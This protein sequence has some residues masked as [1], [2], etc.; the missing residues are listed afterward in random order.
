LTIAC[1]FSYIQNRQQVAAYN[2]VI[3][4]LNGIENS[5]PDDNEQKEDERFKFFIRCTLL[6]FVANFKY[7][8]PRILPHDMS[9]RTY[10]VE[11]LSPIFRAFRNA[12]P[13][14]H[15]HWIEKDIGS[16]KDVNNMFNTKLGKRKADIL[17][18]RLST[19]AQ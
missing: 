5:A 10:I 18:L 7:R 17:I 12:F 9:E 2:L 15:Y 11:C 1:F 8:I 16:I 4:K 13:D 19:D 14:Y 6:D 3:D